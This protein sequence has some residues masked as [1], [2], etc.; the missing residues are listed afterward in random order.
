METGVSKR[1][2]TD[3]VNFLLERQDESEAIKETLE[4]LRTKKDEELFIKALIELIIDKNTPDELILKNL[5]HIKDATKYV[6]IKDKDGHRF[7]YKEAII[8]GEV[9]EFNRLES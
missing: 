2:T 1:F 4:F 7:E 3:I 6:L 8:L 9:L 5:V